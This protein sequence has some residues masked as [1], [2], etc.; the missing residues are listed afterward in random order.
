MIDPRCARFCTYGQ[1]Q[2]KSRLLIPTQPQSPMCIS[3]LTDQPTHATLGPG[4][5]ISLNSSAESPCP[6][7]YQIWRSNKFIEVDICHLTHSW[8]PTETTQVSQSRLPQTPPI[9]TE[10][11]VTLSNGPKKYVAR[12]SI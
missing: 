12:L 2:V 8:F 6:Q 7:S 9:D 3:S 1:V 4:L 5:P 10:V 11:K